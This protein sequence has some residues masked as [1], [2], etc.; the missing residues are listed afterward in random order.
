M[1]GDTPKQRHI[2]DCG[3]Q[4]ARAMKFPGG[5]DMQEMMKQDGMSPEDVPF[6]GAPALAP[7]SK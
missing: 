6:G 1:A 2:I 4:E 7:A 5:F 3:N